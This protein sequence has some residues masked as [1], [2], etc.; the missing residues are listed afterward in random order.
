VAELCQN[1]GGGRDEFD[2]FFMGAY[3]YV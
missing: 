1:F 3:I 2:Y